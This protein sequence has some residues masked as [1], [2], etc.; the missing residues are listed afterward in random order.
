MTKAVTAS[1]V[2][3]STELA[4]LK[5]YLL[6]SVNCCFD[7]ASRHREGPQGNAEKILKK[8]R[9]LKFLKA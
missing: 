6:Y 2:K 1:E 7:D 3:Q 8:R 5:D 9:N 4:S